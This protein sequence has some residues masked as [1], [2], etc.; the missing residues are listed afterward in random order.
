VIKEA[1]FTVS[2]TP[3]KTVDTF[4]YQGR[5]LEKNDD[6]WP[7]SSLTSNKLSS[8]GLESTLKVVDERSNR[9]INYDKNTRPWFK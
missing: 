2:D 6:D 8:N 7:D 9:L 3:M 1:I 5:V 4:K